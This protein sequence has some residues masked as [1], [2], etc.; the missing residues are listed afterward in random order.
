[1]PKKASTSTLSWD[2]RVLP[3][4]NLQPYARNARTHSAK[5]LRQI[6]ASIER[7]GFN[8]PVLIDREGGIIAG[9]GRVE[10]ARLLGRSEVPT[11][12]LDHLSPAQKRA[13]VIADNRI[14]QLA[15]WDE[16]IL[17][18]E[19]QELARID[20]DFDVA[21]TGFETPDIDVLVDRCI[22]TKPDP[23]DV[24]PLPTDDHPPVSQLGDVWQLGRHRLLCGSAIVSTDY[25]T[26]LRGDAAQMVFTDPP[27]NVPIAGNVGGLGRVKHKEFLMAS[28]EMSPAQ[29]TDFL[30]S[31]FKLL[32][33]H[34]QNGAINFVCMDWRHLGELLRAGEG[35]YRE[36]KNL[37][38]WNKDNAGMGSFYRSKHELIAVYK[39]GTAKHINNFQLGQYGRYRSN[40]WDYPGINTLKAARHEEL[41]MHPT[42]KPVALVADAIKDCSHRRGIVLDAFA[43]SGTTII[44]AEKTGRVGRAMELDPKYVDVAVRRWEQTTGEKAIHS[45]TG[46]TFETHAELAMQIRRGRDQRE[47]K[48]R[49]VRPRP[50][51]ICRK[52]G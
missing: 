36:L 40:V 47:S 24:C 11:I 3:I 19:L 21:I 39:V 37:V 18:I 49:V 50:R 41:T 31:T 27:Y 20:V 45:R 33:R 17:A 46:N 25:Q 51:A 16:Q 48:R 13:Y 8:N 38:V 29:F 1:M 26:L 10:A 12:R 43:G 42:V 14:A 6:A 52:E 23:A 22:S 9:H 7:F 30:A 28:G 44:A 15:G 5:Q 4:A 32:A 2:V 35:V 34:S